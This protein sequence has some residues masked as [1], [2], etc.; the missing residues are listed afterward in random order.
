MASCSPKSLKL[1]MIGLSTATSNH[2]PFSHELPF[3][4]RFV[5][6]PAPADA[7]VG[8]E[9]TDV[10]EG[11]TSKEGGAFGNS[12]SRA[13]GIVGTNTAPVGTRWT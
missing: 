8:C 4:R 13:A 12:L 5:T 7:A 2:L 6:G 10:L 9:I 11:G 3:V 1:V